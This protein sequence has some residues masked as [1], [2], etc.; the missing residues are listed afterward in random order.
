MSNKVICIAGKNSIAIHILDYVLNKYSNCRIIACINRTDNFKNNW[1]L[2]FAKHCK[3]KSIEIV[4]LENI[5]E[6]ENLYFISLEFDKLIDVKKFKTKNLFN[7]HFSYLP[8]YKGMFTSALPILHNMQET[9]VTLHLIDNGIDTGDIIA[10]KSFSINKDFN[11]R[12]LYVEYLSQGKNLV[13]ENIDNL[14]N[15]SF[16]TKRQPTLNSSYFSKKS[17]DFNNLKI[18]LNSTADQI[19]NQIRA[20]SFREYQLPMV[21]GYLIYKAITLDSKSMSKPG[22]ILRNDFDSLIVS[23][24]DYDIKLL[25]DLLDEVLTAAKNG[26]INKVIIIQNLGFDITLKDENGWDILIIAS[27]NGKFKL[28]KWII[29]NKIVDINSQNYKG[30]SVIMYAMTYAF[31]SG[32][33]SIMNYLIEKGANLYLVDNKNLDIFHYAKLYDE[34][35][36]CELLS[37]RK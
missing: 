6:I 19:L 25:K 7:I 27:F 10:Q 2:S 22:T 1:Q 32:D 14:L 21:Y 24:I 33:K 15:N 37:I 3:D 35:F 12:D 11:C 8:A 26:E 36:F 5:Y 9:G 16:N 4:K 31:N 30:T 28:V 18:D 17:I 29:D 13:I 23:T 20:F 34:T